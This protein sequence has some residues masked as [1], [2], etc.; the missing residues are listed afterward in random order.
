MTFDNNNREKR[1]REFYEASGDKAVLWISDSRTEDTSTAFD[2]P[3]RL[4]CSTQVSRSTSSRITLVIDRSRAAWSTPGSPIAGGPKPSRGSSDLARSPCR[5]DQSPPSDFPEEF[6]PSYLSVTPPIHRR[7][8][9]AH[10]ASCCCRSRPLF[11]AERVRNEKQK[12]GAD[13]FGLLVSPQSMLN[14]Y[15]STRDFSRLNK[16]LPPGMTAEK[17]RAGIAVALK[18]F[19]ARGWEVD[20]CFVRPDETAG[21]TVER[22]LASTSYDCVVIG[23]GVRLPPRHLAVFGCAATSGEGSLALFADSSTALPTSA[24]PLDTIQ[25]RIE[26]TRLAR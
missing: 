25:A 3:V 4:T 11:L 5:S 23:A 13:K 2:T 6:R 7:Q 16:T 21:P 22:Q 26:R 8:L 18:Q 20:V 12:T 14:S 19:A 15:G 17:I 10:R 1:L 24:D 9:E